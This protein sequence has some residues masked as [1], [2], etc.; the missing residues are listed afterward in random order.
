MDERGF[1]RLGKR[2]PTTSFRIHRNHY[3]T[4]AK[5]KQLVCPIFADVRMN[6]ASA[7]LPD[8]DVPEHVVNAGLAMDTL[9]DFAASFLGPASLRDPAADEQEAQ[10]DVEGEERR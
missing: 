10:E 4:C 9:A 3:E 2:A 5:I 1:R 8:Y 6:G 7:V